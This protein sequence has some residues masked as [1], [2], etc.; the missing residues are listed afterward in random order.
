MTEKCKGHDPWV[1][2][3]MYITTIVARLLIGVPLSGMTISNWS[4]TDKTLIVF[5]LISYW[6]CLLLQGGRPNATAN[7]SHIDQL[8]VPQITIYLRIWQADAF[9]N[10]HDCRG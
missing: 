6:Q 4:G 3:S 2:C 1:S 10:N 8:S 7:T 5:M 9:M